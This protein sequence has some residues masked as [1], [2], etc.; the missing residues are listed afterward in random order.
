MKRWANIEDRVI[1]TIFFLILIFIWELIVRIGLVERFILPSP[2]DILK[3]FPKIHPDIWKHILTTI[4][5][6]SIGFVIAIIFAIALAIIMD[7]VKLIKKAIYPLIIVSQT[8]PI[9]ALAPLFS[10]WFGLGILPKVVVVILVCFFPILVSLIHG[11]ESVDRDLLNL[12]KS[13]GASRFQIFKLVKFPASLV[14]FFSGLRIAATYSIMGAV[15]GEWLGGKSGLGVY[16][17]RV[18]HSYA[19]DKFFA[20]IVIIV[21]LSMILFKGIT[22]LQKILMPWEHSQ[23]KK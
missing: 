5:E 10:I 3:A 15:I 17:L 22:A 14:S 16:M 4:Q 8:V 19:L 13:M 7:N 23:N 6:A 21:V 18:K 1:P 20:V 9:I 2:S 12:L 11:L